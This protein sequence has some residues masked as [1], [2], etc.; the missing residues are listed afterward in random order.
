MSSCDPRSLACRHA[1]DEAAVF[2]DI[3]DESE[4]LFG[5]D[6][7]ALA[8]TLL[9]CPDVEAWRDDFAA[10]DRFVTTAEATLSDGPMGLSLVAFHPG[11]ARWRQLPQE[12]PASLDENAMSG[13][14][15]GAGSA[16][17]AS[18]DG[19]DG[20]YEVWAHFEEAYSDAPHGTGEPSDEGEVLHRR[21]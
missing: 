18:G 20:R 2:E 21:S 12:V 3:V 15:G 7:P 9:A 17:G 19:G 14:A 5:E 16:G 8:T 4:R 11:F 6:A 10:F 13:G 1:S